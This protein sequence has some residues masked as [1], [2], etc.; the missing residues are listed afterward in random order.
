MLYLSQGI[1]FEHVEAGVVVLDDCGD[2]IAG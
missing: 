2:L 1:L